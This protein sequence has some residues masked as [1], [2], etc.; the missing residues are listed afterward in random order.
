MTK[1]L[2]TRCRQRLQ[3]RPPVV[4]RRNVLNVPSWISSGVPHPRIML[5]DQCV[6]TPRTRIHIIKSSAAP[7]NATVLGRR[8]AD[9]AILPETLMKVR[10]FVQLPVE[11]PMLLRCTFRPTAAKVSVR[12]SGS[13]GGFG[14]P[15]ASPPQRRTSPWVS[16]K[17]VLNLEVL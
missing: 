2:Q 16:N 5:N 15:F 10:K 8:F 17:G 14:D 13:P 1:R 12:G 11:H 9:L 4:D 6:S 7:A 3:R